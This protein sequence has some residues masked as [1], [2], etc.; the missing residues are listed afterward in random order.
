MDPAQIK[1]YGVRVR[2]SGSHPSDDEVSV[3]Y[4]FPRSLAGS[5]HP[6]RLR[7]SD[8]VRGGLSTSFGAVRDVV[9]RR[10]QA[11]GARKGRVLYVMHG[12]DPLALLAYHIPDSGPIEILAVGADRSLAPQDAVRLQAHLLA[13]L[14]EAALALGRASKIAW[15]ASTDNAAKVAETAFGFRRAKKPP[16][17]RARN[18]HTRDIERGS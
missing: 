3:A 13:C 10:R 12:K 5:R 17:L 2:R 15:A 9:R 16:N 4:D 7:S 8:R 1:A 18:Y 6:L 11:G 14:E